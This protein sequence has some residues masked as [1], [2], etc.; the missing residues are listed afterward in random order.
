MSTLHWLYLLWNLVDINQKCFP[1]KYLSQMLTYFVTGKQ[2][3][4]STK[5]ITTANRWRNY[6]DGISIFYLGFD[7]YKFKHEN[8]E[9]EN[10]KV[11]KNNRFMSTMP[12]WSPTCYV[13]QV[14]SDFPP[15]SRWSM[16]TRA[17]PD[18][19]GLTPSDKYI[20][21]SGRAD[22]SRWLHHYIQV[23]D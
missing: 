18:G 1:F 12:R 23:R 17:R 15:V 10:L 22:Q 21:I 2:W 4:K 8:V 3:I 16:V 13:T 7:V 14:F 5:R 11:A 6:S 20:K 19:P 9:K